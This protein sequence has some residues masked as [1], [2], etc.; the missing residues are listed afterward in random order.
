MS[1]RPKV[2][3]FDS[4]QELFQGAAE[5]F[6]R[7]GREA[8]QKRGRFTVALS[9]GSTP[10]SLHRELV[11]NF[12]TALAWNQVCFFWGDE[13]H[14]PPDFPES[15]YRMAQETLLSPLAIPAEHI[16]RMP[17]EIA[18]AE[19]AARIYQHSLQDF[20]RPGPGEFPR[21]D[22]ILLGMGG[23]GH[24]AS[25]FPNTPGLEERERWVVA[26]WVEQHSTFRITFTYPVLDR[27]AYVMFL[28]SGA[29]KADMVAKAL[30][31]P[32]AHLPCQRVESLQGELVWYLDREAAAK[33]DSTAQ[34]RG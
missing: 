8:I 18:D 17:G 20:F 26:N 15:N 32:A 13:R 16:F 19:L 31:D 6:C 2:R 10:R 1:A 25:L 23:D 4:A 28:I 3:V 12:R 22:F 24:T 7:L 33:L 34:S 21:L 29:T 30:R 9:G 5:T 27:G 14:V 11:S